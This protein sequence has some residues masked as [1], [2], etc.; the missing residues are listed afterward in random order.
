[1]HLPSHE[2]ERESS[3]AARR[4]LPRRL[5]LGVELPQLLDRACDVGAVGP[6]R[7]HQPR[8]DN[9]LVAAADRLAR[10]QVALVRQT[11]ERG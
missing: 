8:A 6:L 4:P 5:P 11:L 3:T 9:P 1:M 7:L 2:R 10:M